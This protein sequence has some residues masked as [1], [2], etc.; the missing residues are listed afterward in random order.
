MAAQRHA[1]ELLRFSWRLWGG[2][3]IVGQ[4]FVLAEGG[5][6]RAHRHSERLR[7][8]YPPQ[9][10]APTAA[11]AAWRQMEPVKDHEKPLN[12]FQA[13]TTKDRYGTPENCTTSFRPA[14]LEV[15]RVR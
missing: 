9:P 8:V 2:L 11:A 5:W 6:T 7:E 12:R 4:S 10:Q 1:L 15:G 3:L 13:T 14:S